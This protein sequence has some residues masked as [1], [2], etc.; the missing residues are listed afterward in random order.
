ML[1]KIQDW[2]KTLSS[3]N[4]FWTVWI[5]KQYVYQ[6]FTQFIK[7]YLLKSYC[8]PGSALQAE[9]LKPQDTEDMTC[10]PRKHLMFPIP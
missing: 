6:Y 2:K 8:V 7:Q 3:L 4:N 1:F 10:F 9:T 5:Q